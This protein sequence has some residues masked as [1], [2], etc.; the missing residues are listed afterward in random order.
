MRIL[1][2]LI[3]LALISLPVQSDPVADVI[4]AAPEII[5]M[6]EAL[7]LPRMRGGGR[8]VFT[9]DGLVNDLPMETPVEG[10]EVTNPKGV[11]HK[12][13]KVTANKEGW[14]QGEELYAGY[15]YWAFES[16]TARTMMLEA[17]GHSAVRVNG[18]WRGG[19]PY[20]HGLANVPVKIVKGKN[21]LLF[22]GGRGR[23]KARLVAIERPVF[24][25]PE[26]KTTPFLL[27]GVEQQSHFAAVR[28]ANSEDES[29]RVGIRAVGGAVYQSYSI[30]PC[31][32]RK[33]PF[34]FGLNHAVA[35][36]S[37]SI[38]FEVVE[39]AEV[40]DEFSIN[41]RTAEVDDKRRVTFLSSIDGSVQYYGLTPARPL[42]GQTAKPGITL[43]LHG[44]SVEGF[45]HARAY[46][47]KTWCHIVAPTN[48]RPFGFDWEDWGRIDALEV[49]AHA[50]ANLAHDESKI[51][52]TGH[53]MGGHGTWTLGAQFP[54]TFCAIAPC[55]GWQSFWTYGGGAKYDVAVKG[56]EVID[57]CAN[58]HRHELLMQNYRDTAIFVL[59]GDADK[60]VPVEEARR[61]R[62][63]LAKFH[64]DLH[65][66]EEPDR[67]HW[68]DTDPEAGANCVDYGPIFELFSRRRLRAVPEV[69]NIDF[70]TVW[71]GVSATCHWATIVQQTVP[72][73]PSRIQLQATHKGAVISGSVENVQALDLDV[74]RC[75]HATDFVTL[76][77]GDTES[78]FA[79]PESGVLHLQF[80]DNRIQTAK[81]NVGSKNPN[82][83]G[84]FKSAFDNNAVLVYGTAGTPAMNAWAFQKARYD[85]ETMLVRGNANF[86]VVSD[87]EY[88]KGQYGD[89]SVVLYG[90]KGCNTCWDALLEHC[91]IS[92]NDSRIEVT[93]SQFNGSVGGLFVYPHVSQSHVLIGVVAPTDLA[94]AEVLN[95]QNYFVSGVSYPD[96]LFLS[97]DTLRN[98]ERGIIGATMFNNNWQLESVDD[99]LKKQN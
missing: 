72:L 37:V 28:V 24:H 36:N 74:A 27:R 35:G 38:D 8:S 26:D 66:F 17:R 51:Y 61:M 86:E 90:H 80:S 47:H 58:I 82:R 20:S 59:H 99:L 75:L 32:V 4:E 54:D 50:K 89:R 70:T 25:R 11:K 40:I 67:G 85:A 79:W 52:L 9:R 13:A 95:R 14:I 57:A 41:F 29:V 81:V 49:L 77:I 1:L 98:S 48:R 96:V 55:A 16:A 62:K 43:A 31:S 78:S 83:C 23:V 5:E 18:V 10:G 73:Q 33:I 3:C 6:T 42:P 45:G 65:W 69:K 2:S 19:D 94:G 46:G 64:K 84:L 71:P 56:A 44:A 15:A 7:G 87:I 92:I 63:E 12:W 76:K 21:E 91:P 68:Y 93:D 30:A 34:K 60:T 97:P 39:N 22:G 88:E 53:S